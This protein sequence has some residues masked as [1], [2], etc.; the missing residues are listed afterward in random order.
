MALRRM[1][2]KVLFVG[3]ENDVR[4]NLVG[5]L[6]RA[7][8]NVTVAGLAETTVHSLDS[9]TPDL[10]LLAIGMPPSEKRSMKL[11]VRLRQ[12]ERWRHLPVIALS[13]LS[14]PFN[15]RIMGLGVRTVL[16]MPEVTGRDIARWVKEACS[17]EQRGGGNHD[18]GEGVTSIAPSP[19]RASSPPSRPGARGQAQGR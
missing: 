9:C 12:N 8:L 6:R 17:P 13:R 19:R 11:L 18:Q 16:T 1:H 5:Q 14:N 4:E 3:D 10:L 15:L 2:P 7:G